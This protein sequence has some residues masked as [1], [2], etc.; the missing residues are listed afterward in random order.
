MKRTLGTLI[1]TITLAGG[2]LMTGAST[3]SAA[4]SCSTKPTGSPEG[5][6]VGSCA[7]TRADTRIYFDY[8]CVS[9]GVQ[10][11]NYVTV[12]YGLSFRVKPC[13]NLGVSVVGSG[14][15]KQTN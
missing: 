8:I 9:N 7:G 4:N 2:L 15:V 10:N 14:F 11:R 12:G 1:A 6:V 5:Y 13:N 3:A